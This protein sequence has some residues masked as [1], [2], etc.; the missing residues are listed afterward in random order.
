MSGHIAEHRSITIVGGF[1]VN[2]EK[3]LNTTTSNDTLENR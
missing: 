2:M 1:L 3:L